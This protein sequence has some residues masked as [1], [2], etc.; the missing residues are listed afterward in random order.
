MKIGL[1]GYPLKKSLSKYLYETIS[2]LLNLEINFFEFETKEPLKII[3]DLKTNQFNG[4]FITIPYKKTLLEIVKKDKFVKKTHNLNCVRIDKD[5]LVATNT[6]YVALKKLIKL[7]GIK[8]SSKNATII[9]N[10]ST[11]LTSYTLLKDFGIDKITLIIRDISKKED[12]K[13]TFKDADI[14]LI[15]KL[16]KHDTHI[17]INATPL[18]MYFEFPKI[19]LNYDILIDFAYLVN[20]TFLIKKAKKDSKIFIEGKEILTMQ[21]I[22]GLKHIADIDIEDNY[23]E[24]YKT[25]LKNI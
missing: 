19:D 22:C 12:I 3:E 7:K 8:I 9:G 17:L 20:E 2:K 14:I 18:G 23:E 1:I 16:K 24:I 5:N 11:A 15:S 10:G 6:D 4:F 21:G 25:F 13:S